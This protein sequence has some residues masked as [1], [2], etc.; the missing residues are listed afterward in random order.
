MNLHISASCGQCKDM[1]PCV[2]IF[3]RVLPLGLGARGGVAIQLLLGS[4]VPRGVVLIGDPF[5]FFPFFFFSCC[6]HSIWNSQAKDPIRAV[7]ATYT[8]ATAALDPVTHCARQGLKQ[9]PSTPEM[10]PVPLCHS[11]N[12]CSFYPNRLSFHP[13]SLVSDE[14][15]KEEIPQTIQNTAHSH[16]KFRQKI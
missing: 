14:A 9:C 12:S 5:S 1:S 16:V 2:C 15:A 10:L 7:V 13:P 4:R 3:K 6:P 8:A 11:G